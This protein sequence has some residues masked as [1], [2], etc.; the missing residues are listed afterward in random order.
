MSEYMHMVSISW[1]F[2]DR[3]VEILPE[4]R[5]LRFDLADK[6]VMLPGPTSPFSESSLTRAVSAVQVDM[7][8]N[9]RKLIVRA[10]A[11]IAIPVKVSKGRNTVLQSKE[12]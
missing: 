7:Q 12:V 10:T 2:R 5:R 4:S 1:G 8:R 9:S 11:M 6:A 3:K